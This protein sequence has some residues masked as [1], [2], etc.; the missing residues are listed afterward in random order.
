MRFL[1][2]IVPSFV[3]IALASVV[4][5]SLSSLPAWA[6]SGGT[7]SSASSMQMGTGSSNGYSS[8]VASS[9][10]ISLGVALTKAGSDQLTLSVSPTAQSAANPAVVRSLA[11]QAVTF[12][13]KTKV[14]SGDGMM[15]VGTATANSSGVATL[16]YMPTWTG[17]TDFAAQMGATSTMPAMSTSLSYNVAKDPSGVPSQYFESQR[18]LHGIATVLVKFLIGIAAAV[19]LILL[20]TLAVV[21]FRMPR[22]G[23]SQ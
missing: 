7:T 4:G 9:S 1:T 15:A 14:F 23:R 22:L 21:L 8:T 16:N 19:W 17:V 20:G 6:A 2:K 5:L 13:V 11:G 10:E 3:L 18:P 12:Y